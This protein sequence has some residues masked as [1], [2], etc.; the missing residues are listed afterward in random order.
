MRLSLKRAGLRPTASAIPFSH[1]IRHVRTLL[2]REMVVTFCQSLKRLVCFPYECA[3]REVAVGMIRISGGALGGRRIAVPPSGVR[4]SQDRLRQGVF[5]SLGS[6]VAGARVLDLFA[7]S[8]A[9]GI[10]AL[11]R[12]AVSVCAVEKHAGTCAVLRRNLLAL[13]GDF[14]DA[15]ARGI[16]GNALEPA[17]YAAH[18]PFDLVFADPPYASGQEAGTLPRLLRALAES[19]VLAPGAL[20][21]YEQPARAAAVAD[22]AW[23]LLRERDS[24]DSRWLL[25]RLAPAPPPTP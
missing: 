18:G 16:R 7:G 2:Q 12:G 8:G 20:L 13:A 5:S 9:Y 6:C 25:Y 1:V 11:S 17:G 3:L 19:G 15:R 22:S 21:V 23:E 14:P 10:E 4:P 24:G